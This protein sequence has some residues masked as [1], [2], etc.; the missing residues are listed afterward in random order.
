[1]PPEYRLND[2]SAPWLTPA[3]LHGVAGTGCGV[4][5]ASPPVTGG[6]AQKGAGIRFRSVAAAAAALVAAG[7]GVWLAAGEGRQ[8][9]GAWGAQ[10][11]PP[12]AGSQSPVASFPVA[13]RQ[14]PVEVIQSWGSRGLEVPESLPGTMRMTGGRIKA[15]LAPGVE[16]ILFGPFE[17]EV[18]SPKEAKLLSGRLVADIPAERGGF[19]LRTPDLEMWDYGAVFCASATDEGSDIFVFKGEAQVVEACGEPVDICRAGEGARARRDGSGAVKVEAE[20]WP[21]AAEMLA[22]VEKT[23]AAKDP[24]DALQV[25]ARISDEW[26][27]LRMP[28]EAWRISERHR[29]AAALQSSADS[30]QFSKEPWVRPTASAYQEEHSMRKG[31]VAAVAAASALITGAGASSGSSLPLRID[32]SPVH[33]LNWS[34]LF[35]NEVPL[36]WEWPDGAASATLTVT[37]MRGSFVTNFPPETTGC[38]WSP[39]AAA[40]PREEEVYELTLSFFDSGENEVETLDA[41]LAAVAGAFGAVE[42][43]TGLS[44]R[45]WGKVKTN[46]VIPYDA[47]WAEATA[48]AAASRIVI[49]KAGGAAQE[50]LTG[51]ASGYF[52]WKL[53][54]SGWGYGVFALTLDF[55]G[56]DGAW[57]ATLEYIPGGT[58]LKVR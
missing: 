41:K 9:A 13:G 50:Y 23:G 8:A 34:T 16:M 10:R 38:V 24:A 21:H 17:M 12:V 54:N 49:E 46:A 35:D 52:G 15:R 32:T 53:L 4:G 55:P 11:M 7:A 2:Q 27:R 40:V 45:R 25:A 19:T 37:G 58:I 20:A 5:Q 6:E 31:S 36:Q 3:S 29:L 14:S 33:N 48:D 28:E 22:R 51:D 18:K 44:D 43:D 1:M 56:F 26:A 42:V 57:E 39:F 30:A 47:A